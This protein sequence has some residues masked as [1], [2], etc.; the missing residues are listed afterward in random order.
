MGS[1]VELDG[2]FKSGQ[3]LSDPDAKGCSEIV[4]TVQQ[5]SL[6]AQLYLYYARARHADF[7]GQVKLDQI[8]ALPGS[9]NPPTQLCIY[10]HTDIL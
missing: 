1:K 8:N 4:Y 9:A 7:L 3:E 6:L 5:E 10:V 2:P